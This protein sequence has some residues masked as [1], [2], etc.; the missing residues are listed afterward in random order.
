LKD[1]DPAYGKPYRSEK[2]TDDERDTEA[3]MK[4]IILESV[5]FQDKKLEGAEG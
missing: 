1:E 4:A 5:Q 3:L 2:W